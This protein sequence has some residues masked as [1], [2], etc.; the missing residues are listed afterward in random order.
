MNRVILLSAVSAALVAGPAL[1][2]DL[3][4]MKGPPA[5]RR[6][7]ATTDIVNGNN[8]IAVDFL[9]ANVGYTEFAL[10]L[11]PARP[12]AASSTPRPNGRPASTYR[13]R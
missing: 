10:P 11:S 6:I 5:A 9:G 4:T 2:S 1:A 8:Q 3:P 7:L 13:C 12:R